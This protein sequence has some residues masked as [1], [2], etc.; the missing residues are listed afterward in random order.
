MLRREFLSRFLLAGGAAAAGAAL[1][2]GAAAAAPASLLDELAR[3]D[4]GAIPAGEADLPA[5][6]AQ[7]VQR[8]VVVRRRRLLVRRRVCVTRIGPRGRIIRVCRVG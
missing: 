7:E 4:A 2:P 1:V 6:Q 8:V 3:M 5:P